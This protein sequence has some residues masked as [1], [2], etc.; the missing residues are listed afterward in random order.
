[1]AGRRCRRLKKR[2]MRFLVTA[3]AVLS[4]AA[5]IGGVFAYY[6]N[7]Q[8]V[9]NTITVG[10]NITEIEE[11][12]VPDP[13][14]DV[15]Q[16]SVQVVNTGDIPCYVR[17]YLAFSDE[18]VAGIAQL[19]SDGKTFYRLQEYMKHL[20]D[21]WVEGSDGYL[22]YTKLLSVNSK[23]SKLMSHVKTVWPAD[24]DRHDFNLIVREES[25]QIPAN[26]PDADYRQAWAAFGEEVK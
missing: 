14:S 12:F 2:K 11:N 17:V 26:H 3:A 23:T 10:Q 5:M 15:Y 19:S 21:G 7:H 16:K 18:E 4:A 8:E 24:M 1:M 9:E 6:T 25:V 13:T 22:Y 20:P